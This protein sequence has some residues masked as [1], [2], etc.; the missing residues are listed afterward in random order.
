MESCT[1]RRRGGQ[2]PSPTLTRVLGIYADEA[3]LL[4]R[5]REVPTLTQIGK[6]TGKIT[7]SVGVVPSIYSKTACYSWVNSGLLSLRQGIAQLSQSDCASVNFAQD[8]VCVF[9]LF[10]PFINSLFGSRENSHDR[11]KRSALRI[12]RAVVRASRVMSQN[13]CGTV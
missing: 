12:V 11:E 3:Y 8:Y 4:Q 13:A 6:L 5:L 9:A 2:T 1:C 10:S 7:V